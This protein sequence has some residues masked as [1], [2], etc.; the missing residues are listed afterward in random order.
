ML[1]AVGRH[2]LDPQSI[3]TYLA[4][5]R[6][7]FRTLKKLVHLLFKIFIKTLFYG[8]VQYEVLIDLFFFWD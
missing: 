2:A 5:R 6:K 3:E 8:L 4:A 7:K 1:K